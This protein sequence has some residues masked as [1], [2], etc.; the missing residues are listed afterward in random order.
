MQWATL[1]WMDSR[2]PPACRGQSGLRE[3]GA[4][5]EKSW[6]PSPGPGETPDCLD[7]LG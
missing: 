4:S 3:R 7:A 5:L 6:G 2:V 1:A